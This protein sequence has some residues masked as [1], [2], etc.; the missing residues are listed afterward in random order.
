M[1]DHLVKKEKKEKE[2]NTKEA[3]SGTK[4]NCFC[5]QNEHLIP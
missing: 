1:L 5:N 4:E 2:G 3:L